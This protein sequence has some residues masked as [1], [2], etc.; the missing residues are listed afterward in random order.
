MPRI[1]R[2]VVPGCPHHVTQRGTNRGDIL[3]D[4]D[5]RAYFLDCLAGWLPRTRVENWAYCLMTNHI[6]MLLVPQDESG[7]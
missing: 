5:D 2:V 6:H 3:L 1:A 4:G 7:L